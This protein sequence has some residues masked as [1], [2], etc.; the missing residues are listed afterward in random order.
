MKLRSLF[1]VLTA[2]FVMLGVC[3]FTNQPNSNPQGAIFVGEQAPVMVSLLTNPERLDQF[4]SAIAGKNSNFN[5][6]KQSFLANTG[7][8]YQKDVK[9]WIGD[10]ISLAVTSLDYDRNSAN[11][12]QPG[13]LLIMRTKKAES[14]QEFLQLFWQ[15]KAIPEQELI[16][17]DY[18]GVKLISVKDGLASAVVGKRFILFANHLK[19][20]KEAINNVQ[21]NINLNSE[22]NYQLAVKNLTAPNGGFIYFNLAELSSKLNDSKSVENPYRSLAIALSVNKQGL[23]A[24]TALLGRKIT[25]HEPLLKEPVAALQYIPKDSVLVA[26]GTELN[27]LWSAIYY[28]TILKPFWIKS[29]DKFENKF[30][31]RLGEDV[32][33][34][35]Q[36]EYALGLVERNGGKTKDWIFVTEKT[37]QVETGIDQLDKLAKKQGFS[38]SYLPIGEQKIAAWTKLTTR[39]TKDQGN[40]LFSLNAEVQGVHT[41]AGKYEIFT[42]SVEAM[43]LALQGEKQSITHNN[44]WENSIKNLPKANDGYLYLDWPKSGNM[45]TEKV[46]ILQL[47]K[48]VAKPFFDQL[49]SL[50]ITNYGS[51]EGIQKSQVFVQ[52]AQV[53]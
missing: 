16:F 37:P 18:Q 46:S 21:A 53:K 2:I 43:D 10:E 31:I 32:L 29:L 20:L 36:G 50:S 30:G 5:Q 25:A 15:K 6:F 23:Q 40:G 34:W 8:N 3:G 47:A 44:N 22:P 7:L 28:D 49:R 12:Q 26:S 14:S 1:S 41:T 17:D 11:G 27:H 19:V 4:W 9:P 42:T 35:N 39:K 38:L 13:Y 48:L 24:D 52:F 51:A 33:N 45:I